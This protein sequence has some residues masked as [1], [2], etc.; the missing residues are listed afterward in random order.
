LEGP[1]LP[2]QVNT[3]CERRPT[4]L[5][6]LRGSCTRD[7]GLDRTC[8]SQV[9]RRRL[10]GG[11]AQREAKLA[12]TRQ[13]AVIEPPAQIAQTVAALGVNPGPDLDTP[14]AVFIFELAK[15]TS[16]TRW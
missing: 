11:L 5:A 3:I 12:N 14:V 4:A 8:P 10:R 6:K 7:D 1:R 2:E 9:G 16:S 15:G 13:V